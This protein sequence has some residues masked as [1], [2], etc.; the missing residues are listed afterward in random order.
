MRLVPEAIPIHRDT[1]CDP[2]RYLQGHAIR[3]LSWRYRMASC[4]PTRY[5]DESG[6]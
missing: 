2:L 5:P 3:R 1:D 6:Y 4:A